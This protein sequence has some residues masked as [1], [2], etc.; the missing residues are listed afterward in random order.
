MLTEVKPRPKR[1]HGIKPI[2]D[3]FDMPVRKA[4]YL[5]SKGAL[6]GVFKLDG[7]R[8]W[9]IDYEIAEEALRSKAKEGV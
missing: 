8:G 7:C 5:A 4:S 1:G 3:F 6:P 2:A 9:S